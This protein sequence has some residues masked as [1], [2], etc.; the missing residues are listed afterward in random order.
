MYKY[1]KKLTQSGKST[2]KLLQ[3]NER[4]FKKQKGYKSIAH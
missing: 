3:L 1:K 2:N 4:H